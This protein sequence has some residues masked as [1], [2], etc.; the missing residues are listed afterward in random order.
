MQL[1]RTLDTMLKDLSERFED[2]AL[3]LF[4][5]HGMGPNKSDLPAMALVP[6]LMFRDSFGKPFLRED[7]GVAA[8]RCAQ[9]ADPQSWSRS[10]LPLLGDAQRSALARRWTSLRGWVKRG[11]G[12]SAIAAAGSSEDLPLAWMPAAHYQPFW[13]TM[14]SF[15]LPSFYDARIRVNLK[16]REASGIV[17]IG[18]YEKELD[19]IEALMNELRDWRTGERVAARTIRP[20]AGGPMQ[21]D[22]SQC[23]LRIVF[24]EMYLGVSHPVHGMI[25]PLPVRRTGGHTGDFGLAAFANTQA[26]PGDQGVRSTFDFV[27]TLLHLLGEDRLAGDLSGKPLF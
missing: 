7:P 23:D 24:S 18:E 10:V 14:R 19:R 26:A 15:A 12:G 17:P 16:G 8:G 21:A 1:Y 20:A 9:P 11:S 25:G 22:N 5:P 4:S 3:C 27:P 13:H 6:E 2:A